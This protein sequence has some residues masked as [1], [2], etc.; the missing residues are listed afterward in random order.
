[1]YYYE[2]NRGEGFWDTVVSHDLPSTPWGADIRGLM[3]LPSAA[4]LKAPL[5]ELREIYGYETR[6][7]RA[8]LGRRVADGLEFTNNVSNLIDSLEKEAVALEQRRKD[9]QD[10]AYEGSPETVPTSDARA[11]GRM[12]EEAYVAAHKAGP[13][14]VDLA[15][16][17]HAREEAYM[18][19]KGIEEFITSCLRR[20][21]ELTN[22]LRL[23]TEVNDDLNSTNY[24]LVNR[25]QEAEQR[26]DKLVTKVSGLLEEGF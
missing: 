11:Y 13:V 17:L 15:D 5:S 21:D 9:R 8:A 18:Q 22:K 25:V 20:I 1:M 23:Q 4:N 10:E 7:R 16:S 19:V 12:V 2:Q 6:Q 24:D 3:E 26:Y 14:E